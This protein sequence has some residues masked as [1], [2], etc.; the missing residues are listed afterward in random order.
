MGLITHD[1]MTG[2]CPLGESGTTM[3]SWEVAGRLTQEFGQI[4]HFP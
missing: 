2:P 3:V 1:S 4:V